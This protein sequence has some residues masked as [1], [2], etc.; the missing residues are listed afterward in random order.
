MH[1]LIE[2]DAVIKLIKPYINNVEAYVVGGFVRDVL[3][4]KQSPDRDLILCNCDVEEFSRELADK[5]N[6]HFIE[7]DPVNKIYRIVLENKVDYIDITTPI[8][9]DFEKDIKRRDLTINAIAYNLKTSEIV[10]L[11]GGINDIKNKKIKGIS[12][13]NFEDDPLRLLRIF[14]FYAKTGFEIDESLIEISKKLH[15]KIPLTSTSREF[16][17]EV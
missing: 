13:K 6:A 4:N 2:N 11:V 15:K 9:N 16:S 10:D 14:R 12:E 7:L 5:L 3:M 1:N 17:G 8:E